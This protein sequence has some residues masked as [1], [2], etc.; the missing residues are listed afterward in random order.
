MNIRDSITYEVSEVEEGRYRV[1]VK[2]LNDMLLGILYF[3]NPKQRWYS[4]PIVSNKLRCVDAKIET[5]YVHGG[6]D[7]TPKEVVA[8]CQDLL[9][10][11]LRDNGKQFHIKKHSDEE[12]KEGNNQSQ[13]NG[14]VL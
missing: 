7:L 1:E 12:D 8:T 4:K 6:E 10:E 3:E 11:Y 2:L 14:S 9:A 13:D 5:L